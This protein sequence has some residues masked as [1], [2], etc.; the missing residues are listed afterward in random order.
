MIILDATNRTLEVDLDG[1][2]TTNQLPVV[3]TYVDIT[4][5]TYSPAA[6]TT[7]TNN[8]T[9]VTIVAAPAAST[10]RQIKF[11]SVRNADT[12]AA[13]VTIQYNDNATLRGIVKATLAVDDTLLYTDG[14][15][16]RVIDSAGNIKTAAVV[17]HGAM[18]GLSDDDHTQY[19]LLVGRSSGQILI[20]GVDTTADLTLQTTSGVGASGAD[21][22]FLVGNNGA[23]EAVTILNSG[24]IGILNTAPGQAVQIGDGTG[25]PK[26][27]MTGADGG[28][29]GNLDMYVNSSGQGVF[30]SDDSHIL[31]QLSGTSSMV[32]NVSGVAFNDGKAVIFGTNEEAFIGFD[33]QNNADTWLIGTP[34]A[35]FKTFYAQRHNFSNAASDFSSLGGTHADVNLSF[36]D[37]DEDS[38]LQIGYSADDVTMIDSN[39]N[40]NLQPGGSNLGVGLTVPTATIHADQSSAS[41][42][43]PVLRL[44]Q[45]DIDDTFIDF[46]GTSAADGT[47]SVSSDTTEDSTKF[48]AVRVEING[49]TKWIRIYDNES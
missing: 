42:A 1:A 37:A 43:K 46:I 30:D 23:T 16:F 21:M 44:D 28:G 47:R 26:L 10:Q 31:F 3:A 34:N 45:G 4:T 39:R 13:V 33:F 29:S 41:G 38:Y 18:S 20:G 32:M 24:N 27:R 49:V 36:L 22:H 40:L 48:G 14:E 25:N 8:T 11:L 2:I 5:T 7:Q 15:G 6:N 19:A 35:N 9:A 12:A 17:D